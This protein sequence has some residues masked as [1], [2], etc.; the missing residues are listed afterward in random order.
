MKKFLSLF[1]CL[2]ILIGAV[3]LSVSAANTQTYDTPPTQDGVV[4]PNEYTTS[5]VYDR[6]NPTNFTPVCEIQRGETLTEYVAHDQE[7]VYIAFV[8]TQDLKDLQLNMNA[9]ANVTSEINAAAI[10]AYL[11]VS[12]NGTDHTTSASSSVWKDKTYYDYSD[13]APETFRQFYSYEFS[14]AAS[15]NKDNGTFKDITVEFKLSKDAIKE[16]FDIET[17]EVIGQNVKC[18]AANGTV[19]NNACWFTNNM[20]DTSFYDY[21]DFIYSYDIYNDFY[22]DATGRLFNFIVF[23]EAPSSFNHYCSIGNDCLSDRHSA[24]ATQ[25]DFTDLS[26]LGATQS[27]YVAKQLSVDPALFTSATSDTEENTSSGSVSA[28]A[29]SSSDTSSTIVDTE[30]SFEVTTA[31][32]PRVTTTFSGTTTTDQTEV[33]LRVVKIHFGCQ[34]V[35]SVSAASVAALMGACTVLVCR[36]KED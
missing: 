34:N 33:G 27:N 9:S 21:Y 17:V 25:I 20:P 19:I 23:R 5:K 8:C 4:N 29:Q 7:Y 35:L 15:R 30:N 28:T 6:S 24:R 26:D 13:L 36:K 16:I 14:V 2:V 31:V 12:L 1:L 10:T 18:S 22:Y 11:T 32:T 3:A